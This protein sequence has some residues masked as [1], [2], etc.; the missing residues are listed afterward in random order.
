MGTRLVP[1]NGLLKRRKREWKSWIKNRTVK[2]TS[3]RQLLC[4]LFDRELIEIRLSSCYAQ[5]GV[6]TD[7][8][9]STSGKRSPVGVLVSCSCEQE[10]DLDL[11]WKIGNDIGHVVTKVF[12]PTGRSA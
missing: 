4:P 1:W 10:T 3:E 12:Q 7:E 6:Q 9:L 11:D 5:T 8:A 2:M